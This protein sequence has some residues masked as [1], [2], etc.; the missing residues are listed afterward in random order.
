MTTLRHH[1]EAYLVTRRAM[2]FKMLEE[3]RLLMAFV[4][5]CESA[6]IT[7][8]LIDTALAWAVSP[9]STTPGW[10]AHRLSAVRGFAR[11]LVAFDDTAEIPPVDLISVRR[12]RLR[13]FIYSEADVVAL[14]AAA[15]G[16]R[17]PLMAATY[18]T[19]IG[20]LAATGMRVGEAIGLDRGDLD[21][22]EEVLVV[23]GAKFGKSRELPLHPS[24]L[25]ALQDYGVL[26]D[27]LCRRPTSP[28]WFVSTA[29][30]RLIYKNVQ[31]H[32][33]RLVGE[34]GLVSRDGSCPPRI[35]DLRHSFAVA[36]LVEWY[37]AGVDVAAVMPRLSTYLGHVAPCSTYWYLHGVP[38]LLGLA[39]ARLETAR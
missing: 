21:R 4:S 38:E 18:S 5:H 22:K 31:F 36:T 7:T 14:M 20:L 24:T 8:V 9:A 29:G 3:G 28:A 34:V 26:R 10:W 15:S 11:Y 37:R 19:L 17:R 25:D 33:H 2:G 35:H 13:P 1:A 12:T 16:M 23:R 6:G 27:R 32:F 39:A 30:T